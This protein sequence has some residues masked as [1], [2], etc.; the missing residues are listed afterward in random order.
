LNCEEPIVFH[1]TNAVGALGI[2]STG[3]LWCSLASHMNDKQECIYAHQVAVQRAYHALRQ[4]DGLLREKFINEFRSQLERISKIKIYVACFSEA[5]DLL[6]QWRG[7]SGLNGYSLG[8]SL[9]DLRKLSG[10]QSFQIS[11]VRY[12]Q[13]EHYKEIDPIIDSL[14]ERYDSDLDDRSKIDKV[15]WRSM[16]QIAEKSAIIKH[17]SFAEERE[18][19]LHSLPFSGFFE[20]IDFIIREDQIV[21]IFKFDL[22][23]GRMEKVRGR[24]LRNISFRTYKV[25]PG[26]DQEERIEAILAIIQKNSLYWRFGG[27]SKVQLR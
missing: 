23:T 17:P 1:Y 25:G 20:K 19:R 24:V 10:K 9:N 6:S 4:S 13:D 2:L 11:E 12:K 27:Q 22:D 15:F 16:Q 14:L 21:P 3:K 7:Y 8:F 26:A 18:W 5:E